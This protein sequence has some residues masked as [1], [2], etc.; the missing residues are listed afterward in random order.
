MPGSG[1]RSDNII[2][3]ARITGATEFHTSARTFAAGKMQFNSKTMNEQLQS[4]TLDT[5]EVRKILA[6]LKSL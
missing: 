6:S 2:Q 1:V 4:V 5:E 3:I